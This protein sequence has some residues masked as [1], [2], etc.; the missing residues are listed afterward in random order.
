[1]IGEGTERSTKD[2]EMKK[3][4]GNFKTEEVRED[5]RW[6]RKRSST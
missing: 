1:L 4:G 3:E 5:G 2:E 6:V